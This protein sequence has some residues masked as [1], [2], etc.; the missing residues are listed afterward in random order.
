MDIKHVAPLSYRNFG[1]AI[2]LS[3]AIMSYVVSKEKS[4][5]DRFFFESASSSG[6]R[7]SLS[8]TPQSYSF[9]K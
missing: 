1:D 2:F 7:F 9:S 8:K 3:I 4:K 6:N 5:T